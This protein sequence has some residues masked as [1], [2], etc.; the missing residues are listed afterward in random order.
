[1]GQPIKI[2]VLDY[3]KMP[4]FYKKFDVLKE[5]SFERTTSLHKC[6]IHLATKKPDIMLLPFIANENDPEQDLVTIAK[7]NKIPFIVI[8]SDATQDMVVK[9]VRDGALDY[10]L[11]SI[12]PGKFLTKIS[13]ILAKHGKI[14]PSHE[15]VEQIRLEE[16]MTGIEKILTVLEKAKEVKAMPYTVARVVSLCSDPGSSAADIAKPIKTDAALSSS[17]LK[18]SNSVAKYRGAPK[19]Q[20]LKNAIVRIGLQETKETCMVH[21]VYQLFDKKD[22]TFGFDRYQF[23]IHSLATGIICKFL[24][25]K[26]GYAR[27]DSALLSGVLHDLGKMIMDDYFNAEYDK[28]IRIAATQKKI[29]FHVENEILDTNHSFIGGK[30]AENWRFPD[31]ITYAIKNHH[32]YARCFPDGGTT[33][34]LATIVFVSNYLAKAMMLGSGSD[35]FVTPVPDAVWSKLGF[36]QTIPEPFLAAVRRELQDYFSLLKIPKLPSTAHPEPANKDMRILVLSNSQVANVYVRIYLSNNNYKYTVAGIA[37]IPE[38]DYDL[39]IYDFIEELQPVEMEF[40]IK[41][42]TERKNSPAIFIH[43]GVNDI[44]VIQKIHKSTK[45]LR[46]PLDMFSFDQIIKSYDPKNRQFT[47]VESDRTEEEEKE[48]EE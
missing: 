36:S 40:M 26:V 15:E 24:A 4:F 43:S 42:A 47:E 39:I 7:T 41:A 3:F 32:D 23:W 44:L 46:A 38:S 25:K 28:I 21:A 10:I 14:P 2:L 5:F 22:K 30:I 9:S 20:T 16:S 29:L 13:N 8:N 11:T 17:I 1:M 19:V 34:N 31:T 12:D 45:S 18:H 33:F 27:L 35:F 37:G 48:T 6:F